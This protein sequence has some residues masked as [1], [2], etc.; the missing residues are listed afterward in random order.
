MASKLLRRSGVAVGMVCEFLR[1]RPKT[2]YQVGVGLSHEEVPVLKHEWPEVEFV[3]LEPHPN[4]IEA[5]QDYPGQLIQVAAS[6]HI[7]Q[8]KL[9]YH[10]RHK[11]G[12]SLKRLIDNNERMLE[13]DV[14]VVTLDW[15]FHQSTAISASD[16]LWLDCEGSE[17]EVLR[18]SEQFIKQIM[19]VNVELTSN[20]FGD[21]W[22]DPVEVDRWLVEHGFFCQHIHTHRL[23][24]GQWDGIYCRRDIFNSKYCCV[25]SEIVRYNH[26]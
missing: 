5:I 15:L 2:I 25:P 24:S 22:S 8:E 16:M 11:D 18:G 21:G 26:A 17:L 3:G 14:R 1:W 10:R 4:I 23:V 19:M 6:D 12:S 7:G 9:F 20:P 13:V